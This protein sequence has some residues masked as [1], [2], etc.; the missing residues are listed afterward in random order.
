MTVDSLLYEFFIEKGST[1][2]VAAQVTAVRHKWLLT[3]MSEYM[4]YSF[5]SE[6]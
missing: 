4:V 6:T 2:V 3:A 5:S 1:T